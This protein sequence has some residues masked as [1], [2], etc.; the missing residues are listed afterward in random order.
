MENTGCPIAMSDDWSCGRPIHVP[1]Y[2]ALKDLDEHPVCL[3]HSHDLNKSRDDFDAEI[4]RILAGTSVPNYSRRNPNVRHNYFDFRRNYFDFSRFVFPGCDFRSLRLNKRAVFHDTTFTGHA[5]FSG[6][7]FAKEVDFQATTFAEEADFIAATFDGPVYFRGATFVKATDFRG[8]TFSA[9]AM[10]N[11][12]TFT[13]RVFFDRAIFKEADF[14]GVIFHKGADLIGTK[15]TERADFC[16]A[17]F[18]KKADFRAAIFSASVWFNCVTFLKDV[19][20][21]GITVPGGSNFGNTTFTGH[22]LFSR[23]TFTE[24]ADFRSATFLMET[25]FSGTIFVQEASFMNTTFTKEASFRDTTFFT[26]A[27]FRRATFSDSAFF[28]DGTD[29]SMDGSCTGF[30][31]FDFR[32]AKFLKSDTIHFLRTY[33]RA[34]SGLHVRLANCR[35]ENVRFEAVHWSQYKGR[36]VLQDELDILQQARDAPSNEEVAIV[37]RQLISIFEKARTYDLVEDC[38]IGEFEMKRTNIDRFLFAEWLKPIYKRFTFVRAI[39]EWVSVAGI[40]RL[41][42]LYGTSYQRAMGVLLLLFLIFGL[43]FSTIVHIRPAPKLNGVATCTQASTLQGLCRGLLH[44]AEVGTL[45]RTWNY[46]ADSAGG[47]IVEIFQQ[48]LVAGQVALLLFA[49]RRRFRR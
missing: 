8:V 32:Q 49:L 25:D 24:S 15:F 34:M 17:T 37:Y 19:D 2:L 44:A 31:I 11:S 39:G 33:Q 7:T 21:R 6:A 42:S 16:R 4:K 9:K 5:L 40:Y 41:L 29:G 18:T 10:F 26:V 27:D 35:I 20:F 12:T 36:M 48:V 1:H 43:C 28:H 23:A 30:A 22:A 38:T 47:R 13:E 46:E 45:Q 3:M 14:Q